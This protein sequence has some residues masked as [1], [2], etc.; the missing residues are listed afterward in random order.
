MS[1]FSRF[2]R[3][4]VT[5][6]PEGAITGRD[7][8]STAA[9]VNPFTAPF[10][11]VSKAVSDK[12]RRDEAVAERNDAAAAVAPDTA[13]DKF[14]GLLDKQTGEG[15]GYNKDI[16]AFEGLASDFGNLDTSVAAGKVADPFSGL[17]TSIQAGQIDNPYADLD[18]NV[19]YDRSG[20]AGAAGKLT[21]TGEALGALGSQY[22][23][24][25]DAIASGAEDPAFAA[26]REG[27]FAVLDRN[28]AS[29]VG[30]AREMFAGRGL[31]GTTSALNAQ[32]KVRTAFDADRQALAGT[33]GMQ[34]LG[35]KDTA[36][37][38]ALA[39][40]TAGLTG[41]Q[42]AQAV[43]GNL[44]ATQ[45]GLDVTA[46]QASVTAALAAAG[47]SADVSKT[48]V[49]SDLAAKQASVTAALAAAGGT[50]DVSKT[51]VSADLTARQAE[52][53]AALAAKTGQVGAQTSALDAR[54]ALIEAAAID[55][56]LRTKQYAVRKAG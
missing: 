34:A 14:S 56:A 11:A 42:G 1:K 17:D 51:Q 13:I 49:S 37:G 10:A 6:N 45:A 15:V 25:Y 4:A 40:K 43:A 41:Q 16:A 24:Q 7:V 30:A 20:I 18:T 35:R 3:K 36:I 39:A 2:V 52:I 31:E 19:G 27:Q 26:Y 5:G 38:Q 32:N 21:A 28:Q 9:K 29:Q 23:G 53:S 12:R 46:G 33:V 22:G 44:A 50:A 48:Q 55:P 8:L 54:T 47:G